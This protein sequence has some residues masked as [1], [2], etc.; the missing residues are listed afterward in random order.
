VNYGLLAVLVVY[1]VVILGIG[2]W[3]WRRIDSQSEFATAGQ[4]L[5]LPY[6]TASLLATFISALSII[7]GVGYAS[8]HGWAFLALFSLG[9]MGGSVFLSLTARHWHESGVN[10][11]SELLEVRY[12]SGSKHLRAVTAAA[13][14]F[15][16]AVI[17]V[18]QLFGIGFILEGIIGIPMPVGILVVG[19]VITVYTILGGMVSV[20][21]TDAIQVAIMSVGV[22]LLVTVLGHL[23]L[24]DPAESFTQNPD[25]MTLFG[26]VT[27][28]GITMFANFLALG[29]GTA[30]HPYFIQRLLSAEDVETAQLAP[31]LTA[32][33]AFL[34]YISL[35]VVGIVGAIYL[36]EQVGDGMA[37]AIID[38]LLPGVP[39]ALALVALIAVVQSTTDSLLHVIGVYISQDIYAVYAGERSHAESLRLSRIATAG[40]GFVCV[41][42]AT[43][44]AMVGEIGFIALFATYAWGVIGASLFAVVTATFFWKRATWQAGVVAVITG[45]S[46]RVG[47]GLAESAGHVAFDTTGIAVAASVVALVVCSYAT[48]DQSVTASA[49]RAD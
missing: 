19:S 31:A 28:N 7:G 5:S 3:G 15:S 21:R 48:T 9:A 12:D 24:T 23:V 37:P 41:G 26:G 27:H 34:V 39:A 2:V 49:T 22:V 25:H 18:A 8:E 36:P 40:F 14:V 44:Q 42:F 35:S 29:F 43:V 38:S 47:G 16:F 46:I 30:V 6:V 33:G 13:I 11:V 17:L 1:L 10:S 32:V 45:F 20:A 4:G